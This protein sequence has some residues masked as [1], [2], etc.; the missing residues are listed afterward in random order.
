MTVRFS[1]VFFLLL[2]VDIQMFA[3]A[4]AGYYNAAVGKSGHELQVA[5]SQII[6]N[7]NVIDYDD[8]WDYYILTDPHPD[9]PTKLCDIYSLCMFAPEQHGTTPAGVQSD[10]VD[11]LSVYQ[12]EHTFCQSWFGYRTD[13]PFSDMFHIYPVDGWINARRNNNS[14]GEVSAP[15]RVFTNGAKMGINSYVSSV[16]EVPNCMVYEP[17]D[18]YKGDIARS[19]FYMT[20]RY[21]LDSVG[22]STD[23]DMTFRSQLRPWALEMLQ[24]WHALDPVSQKEINRNNA[25]YGIQHNRNPF[26][27]HPELVELIWGNDSLYQTFTTEIVNIVRPTITEFTI[28]DEQSITITFDTNMVRSSLS[29]VNNYYISRGIIID[30][31][32]IVSDNQII[33]LLQNRLI[34]GMDYYCEVSNNLQ[35]L[36]GYFLERTVI[37]F[38]YGYA[39][40]L[41]VIAGWT[42][43][44]LTDDVLYNQRHVVANVGSES[45]QSHF[46]FD[47]THSSSTFSNAELEN[48]SGTI[49]GDPRTTPNAGQAFVIQNM[50]ANGKAFTM[51]CHTSFYNNLSLTFAL[52]VT[53]TGFFRYF[54]E[55]STD[56][57][58]FTAW[59]DTIDMTDNIE[60][61]TFEFQNLD[62]SQIEQLNEQ[63]EIYLRISVDGATHM[64]GNVYFDNVCVRGEKCTKVAEIYDTVMQGSPYYHH[65]FEI[66]IAQTQVVGDHQFVH[67]VEEANSCDSMYVLKLHVVPF[68]GI[69]DYQKQPMVILKP[70]PATDKVVVEGT[71]MK[72]I[73]I[74]NAMGQLLQRLPLNGE[75]NSVLDISSCPSGLY[76]VVV[77][78]NENKRVTRKLLVK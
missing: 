59:G 11:S 21:L 68:V 20:T 78:T 5:L 12:R 45:Q 66:P 31:V 64:A 38:A 55:W 69:A 67:Q 26:I 39:A 50:S 72:E 42:F 61:Q 32:D 17:I 13:A 19:F 70:N 35:S 9:D 2:F 7:H 47:G 36:Q 54:L 30:S 58:N 16:Y 46:Y 29:N 73:A 43:D 76:F 41:T 71:S 33:L 18:E 10:C 24:R 56:G 22:F 4:P 65:G 1:L 52:R 44:D 3:Q 8:L 14:Y 53:A 49:I 25:I 6:D 74:F 63:E 48:Y 40:N 23:Q 37:P 51:S 62:L 34:S 15:S 75:D 28:N 27:D 57:E 77:T 60:I